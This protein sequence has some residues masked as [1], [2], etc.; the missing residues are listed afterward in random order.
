MRSGVAGR[1]WR[2]IASPLFIYLLLA[3]VVLFFLVHNLGSR[4]A[5]LSPDEYA[6]KTAS[7][8]ISS[9]I[10]SPLNAPHKLLAYGLHA[11]SLSWRSAL[12]LSSAIFAALFIFC[13]YRILRAWFG[14]TIGLL[15][16]V[17]LAATPLFLVL[18]RQGSAEIMYFSITAVMAAYMWMQRSE[19]KDLSLAVLLI[20]C[21]FGLYVPG[22]IW[23][24][25]GGL[26]L[27]RK[28]LADGLALARPPAVG[29]AIL[30]CLLVLTPLGLA[31]A[32]DWALIK[33]LA[34]IPAQLVPP[35]TVIKHIAQMALAVF[36]KSPYHST[37]ILGRLS[38]LSIV[39]TALLVFGVY[40]LWKAAKPKLLV[41]LAAAG[42]AV[43]AAGVYDQ[44]SVLA[45][46]LPAAAVIICAGLRYLYIEWR[47]VFPRNPLART[48]AYSLLWALV[49]VQVLFG[50]RYSV[51]AWPNTVATKHVYVLK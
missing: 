28:K 10:N 36:V 39:Q 30:L 32:K 45:L 42:F 7:Q 21:A 31:L 29:A 19:D 14:G 9:I 37:F 13:F 23:W 41:L 6:S 15:G 27:A 47:S 8:S 18:A 24:L 4:P 34:L 20:L 11:A 1:L 33:P 38:I 48:L 22:V 43:I 16:T 12:R 3:A 51:L 44:L 50:I 17:I 5:G 2:I 40:A 25:G 35:L 26:I 49:A 46:G